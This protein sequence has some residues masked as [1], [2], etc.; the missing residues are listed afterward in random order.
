M[1]KKKNIQGDIHEEN[2]E[3]EKLEEIKQP[4]II[5]N[6]IELN[7][8]QKHLEKMKEN[9]NINITNNAVKVL[10]GIM[11]DIKEDYNKNKIQFGQNQKDIEK[12][13]ERNENKVNHNINQ[14]EKYIISKRNLKKLRELKI[15]KE[16]LEK[17]IQKLEIRKKTLE[18]EGKMNLNEVDR[19]IQI[20]ELREIKESLYENKSKLSHIEY[21]I[22]DILAEENNLTRDE[23]IKDF[24]NIVL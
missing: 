7:E 2:K 15:E 5:E 9:Y 6:I 22:K 21:C 1:K 19:N 11:N 3:E 20:K 24:L 14:E 10:K 12:I 18:E 23:K 4:E 13:L 17:K 16:N 8:A